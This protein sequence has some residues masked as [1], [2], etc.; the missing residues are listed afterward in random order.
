MLEFIILPLYE[1]PGP[2]PMLEQG[3]TCETLTSPVLQPSSRLCNRD[4]SSVIM[5]YQK[6]LLTTIVGGRDTFAGSGSNFV[7]D[8]DG[9]SKKCLHKG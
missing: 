3:R 9:I 5:S 2:P 4:L 7:H 6:S 1:V 8:I